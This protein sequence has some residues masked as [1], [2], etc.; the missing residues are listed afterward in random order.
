MFI[1]LGVPITFIYLFPILPVMYVSRQKPRLEAAK[2]LSR[3]RLDVLMPRLGL[4]VMASGLVSSHV[5]IS[6]IHNFHPFIFSIMYLSS[7][8]L[9]TVFPVNTSYAA[10]YTLLSTFMILF[11]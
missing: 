8:S 11:I 6:I 3:P 9:L 2:V 1:I 5:T 7:Y 4:D 10:R